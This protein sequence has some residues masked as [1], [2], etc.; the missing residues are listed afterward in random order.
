V[1]DIQE[2]PETIAPDTVVEIPLLSK[3]RERARFLQ[4]L[5]H[6]VPAIPLLSAGING[7]MQGEHGFALA[8][9]VGE[10]V[11]SVLLLRTVVKEL[12][13][14]RQASPHSGHTHHHGVDWFDIFAAGVLTV[15]ALERWHTHHHLPRPMLVSAAL[16]LALGLF[17]GR[18]AAFSSRRLGLRI[19]A[20]GIRIGGRFIFHQRF[21]PWTDLESIDLDSRE[22]RLVVRGGRDRRINLRDLRNASEVRE[23]L[24]AA[25]ARLRP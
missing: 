3:R 7:L 17:H 12:A 5:Q 8:L 15:E 10:V 14:L 6:V 25:Q 19:D 23:A 20:A 22:A 9:A 11:T 16:T 2:N 4:K 13:A 21:I 24:I 18:F 1:A